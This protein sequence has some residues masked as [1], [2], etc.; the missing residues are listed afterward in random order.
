MK[1]VLFLF[2]IFFSLISQAQEWGTIGS[3]WIYGGGVDYLNA[4]IY[5][6]VADTIIEGKTCR[7]TIS[8]QLDDGVIQPIE[9]TNYLYYENNR[10][11]FYKWGQFN[12]VFDFSLNLGESFTAVGPADQFNV[13]GQELS[14]IETYV[15][16]GNNFRHFLYQPQ[17]NLFFFEGIL[18]QI[19][20]YTRFFPDSQGVYP[21]LHPT[22]QCYITGDTI[23]YPLD[24]DYCEHFLTLKISELEQSG[25]QFSPNPV[26]SK[27][28]LN[29]PSEYGKIGEIRI[30]SLSGQQFGTSILHD[31][32]IELNKA[33]F[34][35]GIYFIEV[36]TENRKL[37]G[38]FVV[39]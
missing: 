37:F 21:I 20:G 16:N 31:R 19:G 26:S 12:L 3:K 23:Y 29:I 7:K 13:G 10:V 6:V 32:Q 30:S 15:I 38:K 4:E 28:T 18:D 8:F 14:H 33:D 1:A 9:S 34:S 11:Y 36:K 17:D 22:I 5:E 25:L 24:N 2:T 35:N 39:E 27:S